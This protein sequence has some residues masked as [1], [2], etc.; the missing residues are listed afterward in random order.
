KKFKETYVSS[1]ENK[2][3]SL[4]LKQL[5][6]LVQPFILRRLKTDP[7]IIKDLPE[8]NEFKVYCSMT[9]EQCVL[10]EAVVKDL[11]KRLSD[12]QG[13]SRKGLILAAL[14]KLKQICNHPVQFMHESSIDLQGR[15][16]KLDRLIEMLSEVIANNEKALIFTQYAELGQLL[17]DYLQEVLDKDVLLLFGGTPQR[18][19]EEL[20]RRFQSTDEG[21]P[22]IFILSIKAGGVGL[23]LTAANHVFHFDRW[24]NPSVE[25]QATDRAY[26]IGQKKNVFVHKFISV[27]TL[28]ENIDQLIEQ[29]KEL[30]DSVIGTGENWLTEMSTEQIREILSLRK[31]T[32]G[33]N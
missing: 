4:R 25:N 15:S 3:N 9:E 5:A 20:I 33:G 30:A 26:R 7:T 19:R 17:R 24:W 14:T 31:L 27:G 23:N 2:Q 1:S 11:I 22:K 16:G 18:E 10:Y 28:E 8:K 21:S 13:I 29:K 12:S 32:M 6:R